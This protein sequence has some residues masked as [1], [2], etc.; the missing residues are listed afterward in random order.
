VSFNWI[1]NPAGKPVK[2]DRG[3]C[4]DDSGASTANGNKVDIWSCNGTVAQTWT[5]VNGAL[6]VRGKCLDDASQGGAGAP[7]VIWICNGHKAQTWT[8]NSNGEYVLALNNLCLT[9]PSGSSVNGTQVLVR[10]CANFADQ[11]W[12]GP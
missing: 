1:I 6:S 10:T 11:H 12:T 3:K 5:F 4:L 8:H 2:G 9:D 7:L